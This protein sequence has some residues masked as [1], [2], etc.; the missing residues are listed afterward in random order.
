MAMIMAGLNR[1]RTGGSSDLRPRTAQRTLFREDVARA[2]FSRA[3][4][5]QI[6]A[7]CGIIELRYVPCVVEKSLGLKHPLG[8]RCQ[9]VLSGQI[10]SRCTNKSVEAYI[11][12]RRRTL[13]QRRK[14]CLGR[15]GEV[16]C[17][18]KFGQGEF[19]RFARNHPFNRLCQGS[20]AHCRTFPSTERV[21]T[22]SAACRH[23]ERFSGKTLPIRR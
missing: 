6:L 9:L 14:L 18:K 13:H 16:K 5:G 12:G 4:E 23:P 11:T 15:G 20:G 10:L 17:V 3:R 21:L 22:Q 7:H 8:N 2:E 1:E 19:L